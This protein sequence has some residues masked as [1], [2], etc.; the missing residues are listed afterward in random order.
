MYPQVRRI[1][2]DLGFNSSV[3]VDTGIMHAW[4][5][6]K[7]DGRREAFS[8]GEVLTS[9][10]PMVLIRMAERR[11]NMKRQMA[12]KVVYAR[13]PRRRKPATLAS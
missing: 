1:L 10:S 11:A 5:K 2:S 8:T 12:K 4:P 3:T 13:L 9:K 6:K 7:L